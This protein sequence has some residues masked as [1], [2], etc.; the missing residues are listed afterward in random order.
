MRTFAAVVGAMYRVFGLIRL[1]DLTKLLRTLPDFPSSSAKDFQ[2]LHLTLRGAKESYAALLEF[3][4]AQK[5]SSAEER[6]FAPFLEIEENENSERLK[7]LFDAFG[8]DKGSFHGYHLLYASILSKI[9]SPR[10]HIAEIGLGTNLTDVPSNMGRRGTPGASLRAWRD[11]YS[12]NCVVIGLDVDNRIL[13]TESG[14]TTFH[15]DQ[16]DPGS[17][18][19]LRG[20]LAKGQLDLFIDDGLH[21]PIANLNFLNHATYFIKS[22]GFLV[23]E[24]IGSRSLVV[25]ELVQRLCPSDWKTQLVEV[26]GDWVFVAQ[27]P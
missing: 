21:S 14:I 8:S 5:L 3:V 1:S 27:L 24:D 6:F 20:S 23:I 11:Y 15:I 9:N 13:F 10:P 18:D 7:N 4:R 12:G 22:G 26:K 16:L 19:T 17:F 2:Y 25:W